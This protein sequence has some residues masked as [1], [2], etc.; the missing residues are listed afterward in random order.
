MAAPHPAQPVI[1]ADIGG[2]HA[3]FACVEPGSRAVT[4]SHTFHT[5]DFATFETALAAYL[6]RLPGEPPKTLSIGAAGPLSGGRLA[7]T[8]GPWTFDP[9]AIARAGGFQSVV[10]ANDLV[11]YAAGIASAPEHGLVCIAEP[12]QPPR[13]VIVLALGTGLGAASFERGDN[14]TAIFPTE[15][16]HMSFAPETDEEDELLRRMRKI[17]PRPTFERIASGSGLPFAYA[18][19]S[20]NAAPADGATVMALATSG[21]PFAETALRLACAAVA[22]IARDLVLTRGGAD[23]VVIGG[24]QGR[25]LERF[26]SAPPF[27]QRLRQAA[28]V[29][30]PLGGLGLYL[31]SAEG[32]PLRGAA[33]LAWG[34]ATCRRLAWFP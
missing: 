21:D 7:L 17:H 19:L 31:V 10:L 20:G 15:A 4:H 25:A 5:H 28:S 33:D 8:N 13:D 3:R 29:P 30:I 26:W 11:V 12:A 23:A 34:T 9:A 24:G 1:A 2:T 18:A 14:G 27:L 32:L 6:G 22:T 16:G